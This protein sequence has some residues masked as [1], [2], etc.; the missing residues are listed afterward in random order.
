MSNKKQFIIFYDDVCYLC[1]WAVN[2]VIRFGNPEGLKISPLNGQ[3]F[4]GIQNRPNLPDSLIVLNDGKIFSQSKAVIS[5]L[6]ELGGL[7]KA[8]G[9]FYSILPD[10]LANSLYSLVA[11]NR[12]KI[13]GKSEVCRVPSSR[14][15]N[16]FLP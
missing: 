5:I 15:R 2:L 10:K 9:L 13:W 1:N 8:F 7:W 11:R 14:E 3:T 16:F 6:Y 12:Y 4:Q